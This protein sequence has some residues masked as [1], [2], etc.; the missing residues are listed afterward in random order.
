[1]KNIFR[2]K[3]DWNIYF[4]IIGNYQV[5]EITDLTYRW[6][7]TKSIYSTLIELI[8]KENPIIVLSQF[9]DESQG[10]LDH[11]E[12]VLAELTGQFGVQVAITKDYFSS[13]QPLSESREYV[14]NVAGKPTIE[15]LFEVLV[16]GGASLSN[17]I[18]GLDTLD[19]NWLEETLKR[20]LK[21]TKSYWLEKEIDELVGLREEVDLLCWTSD[22]HLFVLSTEHYI[23]ELLFSL[24]EL[25]TKYSIII[26]V[27]VK[28]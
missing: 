4:S 22:A 14:L 25:A 19:T 12:Q 27:Q 16:F 6:V 26:N 2:R 5:L 9:I 20:N 23:N 10:M 28:R 17:I 1:M 8:F 11:K 15:W 7:D 13:N 3:K 18:Y 21:F 24:Q